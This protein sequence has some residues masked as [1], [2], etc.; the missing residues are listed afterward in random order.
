MQ[1]GLL[2]KQRQQEGGGEEIHV[3]KPEYDQVDC[4]ALLH[5]VVHFPRQVSH[6]YKKTS[7]R[8]D[9]SFIKIIAKGVQ[10]VG[11]W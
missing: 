10:N 1:N 11:K 5:R 7:K 2:S 9:S 6:A 4:A 8:K 3:V